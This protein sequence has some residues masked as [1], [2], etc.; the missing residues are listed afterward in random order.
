VRRLGERTHPATGRH[1]IYLAARIV[2]GT[3]AVIDH[4]ENAHFDWAD[5]ETVRARWANLKGGIFPPVLAYLEAHMAA[6]APAEGGLD[7]LGSTR[8][9]PPQ[10]S[11]G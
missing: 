11:N 6:P 7:E 3:P 2:S 10:G 9:Q 8:R 1:L 4:E 5:L